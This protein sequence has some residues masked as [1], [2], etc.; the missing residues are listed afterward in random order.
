[1]DVFGFK[2]LA[3]RK[4]WQKKEDGILLVCC[5]KLWKGNSFQLEVNFI[6]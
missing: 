4:P 3:D 5:M 6:H 1:M 2:F